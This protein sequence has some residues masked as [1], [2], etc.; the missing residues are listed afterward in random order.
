MIS[1]EFLEQGRNPVTLFFNMTKNILRCDN[2]IE[3]EMQISG[4]LDIS[5][6]LQ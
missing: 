2:F 5:F 4:C 1:G 3:K 6:A